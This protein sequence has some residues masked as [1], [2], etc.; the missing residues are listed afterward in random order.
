MH[1]RYDLLRTLLLLEAENLKERCK[2]DFNIVTYLYFYNINDIEISS[3]QNYFSRQL[4]DLKKLYPDEVILIPIAIDTGVASVDIFVK[5]L[6]NNSYPS[7]IINKD[8][9]IADFVTL[10]ELEDLVFDTNI[11]NNSVL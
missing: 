6:G 11:L 9:I 10:K 4:F 2:G 5:S 1:R 8:K 3:K 7:I